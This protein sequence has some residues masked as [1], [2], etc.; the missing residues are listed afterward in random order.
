MAGKSTYLRQVALIVLMAQMGSFVPA[1]SAHIGLVDRIF[2]RVGASDNLASGQSTFMVEMVETARILEFATR[3]SLILLDEV[4]RGTSTYDGLSIAWAVAEYLLD[5]CHI[6]SRTLFATH[7]H[8]MTQ[9]ESLREGI[10]N[11]T[12]L[13]KEKDQHI[14][15]LRKIIEG[16]ADRS[17]GIHVAK[18]AG[19]P[20]E[21]IERAQ[22]I[23][24]QLEGGETKPEIH[25]I[26]ISER[27]QEEISTNSLPQPHVI[28]EEVKQMDLFG[29]TPLEA[30]NRLADIK[31]RL[32]TEET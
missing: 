27:P 16:R 8:E 12:V 19:L 32:E 30:L 5:R 24:M 17:Y 11:Y 26:K 20:L 21:V 4:G 25:D 3:R 14:L 1:Q 31:R 13:V 15:F 2:T 6:G 22:N 9:L 18:L 23:L 7:Y 29:M 28:L 10:K